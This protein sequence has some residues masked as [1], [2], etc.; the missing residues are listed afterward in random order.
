[1]Q[2]LQTLIF[3]NAVLALKGKKKIEHSLTLLTTFE[4]YTIN[5]LKS[6]TKLGE[7]WEVCK[8][9]VMILART[10]HYNYSYGQ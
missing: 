10:K 5:D 9:F 3:G 1:M 4:K 7:H 2:T 8:K 6:H